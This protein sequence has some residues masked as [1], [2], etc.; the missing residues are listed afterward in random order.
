MPTPSPA[1]TSSTRSRLIARQRRARPA[2]RPAS[3]LHRPRRLRADFPR[4][5]IVNPASDHRVIKNSL[6][7]WAGRLG[8]AYRLGDKM[9]IRSS[10]SRFYDAWATTVQLSQNF[11]GNWPAVNTLDNAG[12]NVNTPTALPTIRLALGS[13]GAI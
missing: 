12:L 7:D 6:Y 3:T 8:L 2:Y 5:P 13:G 1:N 10:Y 9:V 11:G 4:T